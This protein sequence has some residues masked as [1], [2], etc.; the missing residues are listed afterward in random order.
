MICATGE[1]VRLMTARGS[2]DLPQ[3]LLNVGDV[4]HDTGAEAV[5]VVDLQVVAVGP[6]AGGAVAVVGVVAEGEVVAGSKLEV[7]EADHVGEVGQ[8]ADLEV[9]QDAIDTGIR[10]VQERA[11]GDGAGRQGGSDES[12]AHVVQ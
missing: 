1:A 12:S 2:L 4:D 5:A 11:G 3:G 6:L 9:R 8:A 10:L 7:G